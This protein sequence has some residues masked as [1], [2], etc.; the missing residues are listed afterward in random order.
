MLHGLKRGKEKNNSI[1]AEDFDKA[2]ILKPTH[3]SC[4]GLHQGYG[5]DML[6]EGF[7]HL[8]A[9]KKIHSHKTGSIFCNSSVS[10]VKF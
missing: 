4:S 9:K 6:Q 7:L 2:F 3:F 10:A 5:G 1:P 8:V